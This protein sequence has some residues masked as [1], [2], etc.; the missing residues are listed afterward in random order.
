MNESVFVSKFSERLEAF[1]AEKKMLGFKYDYMYHTLGNFDKFCLENFPDEAELT[2]DIVNG[3]AS[4]RGTEQNQTMRARHSAIREFA[5]YLIGIGETPYWLPVNIVGLGAKP[6]PYVFTEDEVLAFWTTA[7][8]LKTKYNSPYR[9]I[10]LPIVFRVMYC[11][12]LRP[13]E[14]R[15]LKD[16][17]R[18]KPPCVAAK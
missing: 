18:K 17:L 3:W 12:G 8:T 6:I 11:C 16:S 2:E 1:I 15:T 9:H 5:R 10:V 4:R 13:Q 14:A 7:D